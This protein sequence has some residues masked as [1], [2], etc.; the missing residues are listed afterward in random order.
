MYSIPIKI[1]SCRTPFTHQNVTIKDMSHLCILCFV[2]THNFRKRFYLCGVG[3]RSGTQTLSGQRVMPELV[4]HTRSAVSL[5]VAATSVL[6][7]ISGS[8]KRTGR[9]TLSDRKTS[10]SWSLFAFAGVITR[11]AREQIYSMCV[12]CISSGC[13]CWGKSSTSR[14]GVILLPGISFPMEKDMPSIGNSG[15]MQQGINL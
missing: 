1:S 10:S 13:T 11:N 8:P 3:P 14:A 2:S 12:S 4:G 6:R 9:S 15:Q 7:S 5:L